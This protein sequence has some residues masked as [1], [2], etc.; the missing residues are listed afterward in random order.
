[1]NSGRP[2]PIVHLR[3]PAEPTSPAVARTTLSR[4]LAREGWDEDA[5]ALVVLAVF[6]ALT[7]AVEHGSTAG[8]P[9]DVDVAI[10]GGQI[11][12]RVVDRGRH[13]SVA[14]VAIP[15]WPS[16]SAERGR[17]LPIMSALASALEIRPA[18]PGTEVRLVF[19]RVPAAP[20]PAAR[21]RAAAA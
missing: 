13:G 8:A 20:A 4:I 10:A 7:N 6:E 14:P 12:V 16:H 3:L 19:A 21:L 17:G 1:M 18:G 2:D 11:E 15:A 5:A 9:V